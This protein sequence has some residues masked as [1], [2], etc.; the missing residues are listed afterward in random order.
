M[1]MIRSVIVFLCLVVFANGYNLKYGNRPRPHASLAATLANEFQ[2]LLPENIQYDVSTQNEYKIVSVSPLI[3]NNND[4]VTVTFES[5]TPSDLDWIAAYAPAGVDI[6]SY[7]P[8][9]Y[10]Y[11]DE[12]PNYLDESSPD[13]GKGSLIFNFTNL[14]A[15]INFVYF[16]NGTYYPV[17]KDRSSVNVTFANLNQQLRP[18]VTPSGDPDVFTMAWSSYN[19]TKPVLKW[20]TS[21]GTYIY[22]VAASTDTIT[23]DEVCGAPANGTGWWD[24]GL[25][26]TSN[27]TGITS[28]PK[29]SKIYYIFGDEDMNTFSS[30]YVFYVPPTA[31]EQPSDRPTT[32]ILY[33]DLG[34][35]STDDTYTWYEYGRPAINTTMSV[36]AEIFSGNVDAVY[37]GGDIS[38]AT[39]YLSVW[40][41]FMN[42]ISPV[43]GSVLYLSTVG[44][45][46]SDWHH[47][48]GSIYDVTDSGGECGVLTTTLLQQPSPSTIDAPWWSY[49]IGIVH[50]VGISTEHNFTIGSPQYQWLEN[51]LVSVNRT[52]TPWIIFGGHR[53]MYINSNYGG[54]VTSDISVMD[55]LILNIEPLLFKYRVNIG[56]YG[57][58][59]VVQRQAA[60][61]NKQVVQ[62]STAVEDPTTKITTHYQID[63]QA[64]V[65]MVVGTGGAGF[66]VNAYGGNEQPA[67]SEDFF[68][69]WGY[70]KVYAYN[71]TYLYWEWINSAN[72][73]VMDRMVFTQST[74]FS[75][76]WSTP[77]EKSDLICHSVT[78]NGNTG[79]TAIIALFTIIGAVIFLFGL[80]QL[81]IF[82]RGSNSKT[83]FVTDIDPLLSGTSSNSI[84]S[85][86]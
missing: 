22:T 44:N 77:P 49:D 11:C 23:I 15:D 17:V 18:R 63:P 74:D 41:F 69:L 5:K 83:T 86:L 76:S 48:H 80:T 53:A 8:V 20:G 45:H 58:N 39:G 72:N 62:C 57:H 4:E 35:G 47:A 26:H 43:A 30:E 32:I 36:S 24:L 82:I 6:I 3:I 70:T 50:L 2:L 60:V 84:N 34:R 31:G 10:G 37:H 64:T 21:N 71:S 65:Q 13:Y 16:T 73:E 66:T 79:T 1:D 25:I 33:D 40:D 55:E 78:S 68:Y 42:M 27:F 85:R 46:E 54:P 14:R 19:N 12:A 51:D 28:L 56:F 9:K 52:K 67:W 7:V 61:Y 81:W 59:H 29:D 38:Y 75:Q